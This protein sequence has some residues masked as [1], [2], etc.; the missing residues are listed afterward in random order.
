LQK[1]KITP[2]EIVH[3][4]EHLQDDFT[5]EQA[6]DWNNLK[7]VCRDCHAKEHPEIYGK[8]QSTPRRYEILPDGTVYLPEDDAT[9]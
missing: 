7:A 2:A 9:L 3:H 6:L 5:L 8:S 4:I 1:G